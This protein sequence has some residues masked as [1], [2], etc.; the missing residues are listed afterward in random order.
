MKRERKKF[1]LIQVEKK[2]IRFSLSLIY[3]LEVKYAVNKS[4]RN[5][6]CVCC[7]LSLFFSYFLLQGYAH[8][9]FRWL[10]F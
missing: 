2:L 8:V 4:P 10:V 5:D 1:R 6:A 7:S 3:F 9:F